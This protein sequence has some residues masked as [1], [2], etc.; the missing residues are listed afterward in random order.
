MKFNYP[1][2]V[3]SANVT[4]N[5]VIQNNKPENIIKDIQIVQIN[6]VNQKFSAKILKNNDRKRTYALRY[7]LI[8]QEGKILNLTNPMIKH[9][10]AVKLAKSLINMDNNVIYITPIKIVI[11]GGKYTQ[12]LELQQKKVMPQ[13]VLTLK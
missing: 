9:S 1:T 4:T 8:N 3:I 11:K 10:E 12:R 2:T 5:N 13:F 7:Y 6:K